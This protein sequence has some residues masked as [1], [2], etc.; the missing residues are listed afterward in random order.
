MQA[1]AQEV[2]DLDQKLLALLVE[3]ASTDPNLGKA[4]A[5]V[6]PAPDDEAP[7]PGK[8]VPGA[9]PTPTPRPAPAT[10]GA[11][12]V[13]AAAPKPTPKSGSDEAP[14]PKPVQGNA[15]AEIEP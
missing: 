12:P 1:R 15:P 11:K 8:R 3:V 10:T 13:A 5:Y 9:R 4:P 2:I 6:P 14:A 7:K